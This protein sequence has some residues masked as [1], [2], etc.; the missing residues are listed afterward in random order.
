MKTDI[1]IIPALLAAGITG[2][3]LS[4]PDTAS[5]GYMRF[6]DG[7]YIGARED[8]EQRWKAGDRSIDV[9]MPLVEIYQIHAEPDQGIEVFESLVEIRP[10][11]VSARRMLGELYRQALRPGDYVR[12]MEMISR[13]AAAGNDPKSDNQDADRKKAARAADLR[14]LV[15][16]YRVSGQIDRQLDALTRLAELTRGEDESGMQRAELLATQGRVEEAITA[17]TN[18]D[19]QDR[20]PLLTQPSSRRFLI[21]LLHDV[22]RIEEAASRI[23]R[24]IAADAVNKNVIEAG[25][26][27][28]YAGMFSDGRRF[29]LAAT[30]LTS[31]RGRPGNVADDVFLSLTRLYLEMNQPDKARDTLMAWRR[32]ATG[33]QAVASDKLE[34]F[35][36]LALDAGLLDLALAEVRQAKVIELSQPVLAILAET[37]FFSGRTDAVE[38][39]EARVGTDFHAVR[40]VFAAELAAERRQVELARRWALS[41]AADPKRSTEERIRLGN[42]LAKVDLRDA[43]RKEL[44]T[45]M[46]ADHVAPG[47]LGGLALLFLNVGDAAEGYR[48]FSNLSPTDAEANREV[49]WGWAWLT[50]ASHRGDEAIGLVEQGVLDD[51]ARLQDLFFIASN[52]GE[53][54]LAVVAAS[55][56]FEKRPSTEVRTWLAQALINAGRP[57]EALPHLRE[58]LQGGA[59]V[60]GLYGLAL[61]RTGAGGELIDLLKQR[62]ADSGVPVEQRRDAA[63]RLLKTGEREA[64]QAVFLDLATNAPPDGIDV[65]EMLFLWGPRPNAK[66]L[67]WLER[68]AKAAVEP[69]ELASWLSI[70]ATKGGASRVIGLIDASDAKR[71]DALRDVLILALQKSGDVTR[72]SAEIDAAL[73]VEKNPERLESYAQAAEAARQNDL[74]RR[75]WT[76][77]LGVVP[78]NLEALRRLGMIEASQGNPERAA[79]LLGRLLAVTEGDFDACYQYADVLIALGRKNEAKPYLEM[80]LTKL[81]AR[82]AQG[83][84]DRLIEVRILGLLGRATEI[85]IQSDQKA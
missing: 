58:L 34:T 65:Q 79:D 9:I 5:L 4:V 52:N 17:L 18:V 10:S 53:T 61:E 42:V 57:G 13:M 35:V 25:E 72:L 73:S 15:T 50:A 43:A 62:A 49:K 83:D 30:L 37:A 6:K 82:P 2:A 19:E 59:E 26:I 11:D 67:D 16:I 38:W 14:E 8:F 55:R 54:R 1:L 46:S 74:A 21:T 81:R 78:D 66:A 29:D 68:R 20:S 22:G 84:N 48:Y 12:T 71:K 33:T 27:A 60:S 76:S 47:V 85:S 70:L 36:V 28:H 69:W 32:Q 63:F 45:I 56:L 3:V 40:P 7:D 44:R 39:L 51:P 24:W 23:E 77:V 75:A 41:A 31:L 80:A 64:A